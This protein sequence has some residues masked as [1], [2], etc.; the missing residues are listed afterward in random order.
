MVSLKQNC[1]IH[2]Y[3]DTHFKYILWT[4]NN[5]GQS[6]ESTIQECGEKF[7]EFSSI[8]IT[9][10]ART[11]FGS[12]LLQ[13][14]GERT[15]QVDL[16]RVPWILINGKYSRSE[17]TRRE[18]RLLSY[19]CNKYDICWRVRPCNGRLSSV[20][21]HSTADREVSGS[22]PLASWIFWN[23]FIWKLVILGFI[24]K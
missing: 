18:Y 9:N 8:K 5:F 23:I 12:D 22:N 4:I 2:Y 10:C 6:L 13:R 7:P 19:L 15:K 3:P 17:Q 20:V 14:S 1:I 24:N 16:K 21:E 11:D